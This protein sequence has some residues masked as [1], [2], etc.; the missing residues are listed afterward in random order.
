MPWE[1]IND[2]DIRHVWKKACDC[3]NDEESVET[4][5]V[6]PSFYEENG[7]PSCGHCGTVFNYSHTEINKD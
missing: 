3:E 7:E 5:E 2:D 6:E 4:A 1:I